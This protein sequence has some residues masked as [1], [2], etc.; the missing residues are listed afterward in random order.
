METSAATTSINALHAVLAKHEFL[1]GR[2]LKS[3]YN[4][5]QE[6]QQGEC[7]LAR[8]SNERLCRTVQVARIQCFYRHPVQGLLQ[9]YEEKQCFTNGNERCRGWGHVSEKVQASEEPRDAAVRGLAEELGLLV[10]GGDLV[11][12]DT[13]RESGPSESYTGLWSCYECYTYRLDL[14]E[15][16]YRVTY[17]EVQADKTTHFAWRPVY[18]G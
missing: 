14:A 3:V 4:L 15:S 1:T 7:T 18:V 9:L 5:W 13:R 11:A 12:V 16:Q 8:D 17:V 6:L 2:W 10:Q